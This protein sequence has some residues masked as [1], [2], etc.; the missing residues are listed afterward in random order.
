[1]PLSLVYVYS[2][3][4]V[5][6]LN[7]DCRLTCPL[8]RI[9]NRSV[10]PLAPFSPASMLPLHSGGGGGGGTGSGSPVSRSVAGAAG[11]GGLARIA[12]CGPGNTWVGVNGGVPW[13]PRKAPPWKAGP[14][15]GT[16]AGAAAA[17]SRSAHMVRRPR[18]SAGRSGRGCGR[19]N[20]RNL[21]SRQAGVAAGS[22]LQIFRHGVGH[23]AAVFLPR[24]GP[25]LEVRHRHPGQR[26][27]QGGQQ[28]PLCGTGPAPASAPPSA[29]PPPAPRGGTPR[30]GC[31]PRPGRP[32]R[33]T[34][35]PAAPAPTSAPSRGRRTAWPPRPL[36]SPVGPLLSRMMQLRAKRQKR[37]PV[38]RLTGS[39]TGR[40]G[41]SFCRFANTLTHPL[42]GMTRYV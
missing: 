17:A 14:W 20:T 25:E 21:R 5:R 34:P 35:A 13:E 42:S 32:P 8:D 18:M 28:R 6:M 37:E 4:P 22:T 33:P 15:V 24:P 26:L 31:R 19:R 11:G 23:A 36:G 3:S 2:R 41:S 12:A 40:T 10:L 30:A 29:P 38:P 7:A 1:M 39:P 16:W 27:P 9:L